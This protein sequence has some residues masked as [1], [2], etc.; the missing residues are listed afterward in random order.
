[1]V[2]ERDLKTVAEEMDD[3]TY[4]ILGGEEPDYKEF[5]DDFEEMAAELSEEYSIPERIVLY[6][7]DTLKAMGAA[8]TLESVAHHIQDYLEQQKQLEEL[9]QGYAKTHESYLSSLGCVSGCH[10]DTITGPSAH[11]Q[12]AQQASP[13]HIH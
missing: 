4:R 3:T 11:L 1:M 5:E 7:C 12:A 2:H 6:I 9:L 10:D 8:L 13:I